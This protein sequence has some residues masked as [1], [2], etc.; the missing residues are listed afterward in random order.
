MK[1]SGSKKYKKY[2]PV[3]RIEFDS[4]TWPSRQI[5]CAPLFCSVDLRD[6]NQ[7]L[8]EPMNSAQKL[9]LFKL[10]VELGFKQIEIGF[11]A[12][13]QPDFDFTRK[14][15]E[16]KLIP[17]DVTVQVL[18]Q[19]REHLIQRTFEA[20]DGVHRAIVH[21]YNSTSI[22]QRKFVFEKSVEEI[23]DIAEQGAKWVLDYSKQYPKTKWQFEY[24]PESFSQTELPVAKQIC[25]RVIDVWA[26]QTKLPI[27]INLPTT[28]EVSPPNVF[29]DQVEWMGREL[30]HR[31][32]LHISVHTHNDRGGAI[33]SGELA[34]LAGADRVEGTLLGNG[35][36]T[37]NLDIFAFAM[38]L[39]SQGIDPT[40]DVSLAPRVKDI[41]E[42]CTQ[43]QTHP[44]HPW[45]GELVYT[46]FSGSH[47]DAISKSRT[48]TQGEKIWQVAYLPVDPKDLGR[49]YEEVV[50]INSQSGK[51]GVS[52][53]LKKN[54]GFAIPKPMQIDFAKRIQQLTE[55]TATEISP[56]QIHQQFKQLYM[57]TS[58]PFGLKNFQVN[59]GPNTH[60]VHFEWVWNETC[61]DV[62]GVGNGA[63]S[64][65][66]NGLNQWTKANLKGET[67]EVLTY[68]EHSLGTSS[69][70]QAVC[71]MG[72]SID[73]ETYFGAAVSQDTIHA[74]L[75]GIVQCLN[76][77]QTS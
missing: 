68:D 69:D 58:A 63:I 42:E 61:Y 70:A 10:L 71:Y 66:V 37:G 64:S 7:A 29:A 56:D 46:A 40:I 33:A 75:L 30:K 8:K 41:V 62:S 44:R 57:N 22:I 28:V 65:F 24:S 38:N 36:R 2:K 59:R 18:T 50:R 23:G 21:V 20:L 76:Q 11:P 3:P 1:H 26:N 5:T 77:Q 12:A 6:G 60:E 49:S 51:G 54:F 19:A 47:Q 48:N 34:V 45:V 39:Y 43:I 32:K 53:V 4:R 74:A 73:G 27:I 16:K 13:S 31:D 17:E 72:C 14:I 67:I 9:K 35:E 25:N 52:Y 15:I 55:K